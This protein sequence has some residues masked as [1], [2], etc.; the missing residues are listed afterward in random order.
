MKTDSAAVSYSSSIY[1]SCTG[2][3]GNCTASEFAMA[4][5]NFWSI[6]QEANSNLSLIESG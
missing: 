4:N 5:S 6:K 2:C 1:N 3:N